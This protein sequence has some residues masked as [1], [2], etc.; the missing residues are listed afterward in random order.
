MNAAGPS[1]WPG[2]RGCTALYEIMIV[3]VRFYEELN[4][5]LRPARRKQ[6]CIKMLK[7]RTT[8]KDVIESFRVPHTEVDLILVNGN[9]VNFDY[10]PDDGDRISVY[11]VFEAL[12]I[13]SLTHLQERPLRNLKFV[14]DVHL[15][16]LVRRLRILG[17]D[18]CYENDHDDA[19]LLRIVREENR[20]LVTR[21]RSLLMYNLVQ[22]GCWIHAINPDRQTLEI[23][24]RFDL[25][26]NIKPF[27][28]CT[29]CNGQLKPVTKN[30]VMDN[31]EP[32][33]K[34][35]YDTFVQCSKCGQVYWEGSHYSRLFSFVNWIKG[36]AP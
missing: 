6:D 32:K 16:S 17:F 1:N 7:H 29:I 10:S 11:P 25:W 2:K 12:D 27:K 20:I 23:L 26:K 18:V 35:Y 21:D 4:D 5:F 8:V 31:L 30:Q 34:Q 13:S 3:T 24:N 36:Q 28:R 9:S 14:A 15:G 19:D 33:T 22:R